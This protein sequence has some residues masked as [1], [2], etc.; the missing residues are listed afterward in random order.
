MHL[1]DFTKDIGAQPED[2]NFAVSIFFATF[3]LLQPPSAAIGRWMGPKH[4]IPI[5]MVRLTSAGLRA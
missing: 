3:V 5:M 2:L 1:A 4:W